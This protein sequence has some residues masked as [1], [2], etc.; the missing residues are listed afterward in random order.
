MQALAAD[1]TSAVSAP[2]RHHPAAAR[3]RGLARLGA[4]LLPLALLA[5]DETD[6]IAPLPSAASASSASQSATPTVLRGTVITPAGVMKHGFVAI[7]N[8]RILSVSENKPDVPGAT[9]VNTEGIILPGFI[10][11]HNHLMWNVLQRW[12]PT[13]TFSNQPEW[14]GDAAFAPISQAIGQLAPSHFCDMNAWGELR[15]L[16]GGTTSIMATRGEP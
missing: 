6:V 4:L 3:A 8:G 1:P 10:D 5:C 9:I 2:T 12:S 16:V 13:R 7:V 14:N 15:A 11:V